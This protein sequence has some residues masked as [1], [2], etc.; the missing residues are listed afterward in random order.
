MALLTIGRV[1][2]DVTISD[3]NRT[4]GRSYPGGQQIQMRGWLS[5]TTLANVN[6]LRT[7]LLAQARLEGLPVS[8]TYNADATLDGFYTINTVDIPIAV[9]ERPFGNFRYP[10]TVDLT[11]LGTETQVEFQSMMTGTTITNHVGIIESE[12]TPFHAPPQGALSYAAGTTTVTAGSRTGSDGAIPVFFGLDFAADPTWSVTPA[13]YLTGACQI[14]VS[15]ALRAGKEAPND[16]TDSTGWELSNTLVKVTPGATIG[17]IDVSHHDGSQWETAKDYVLTWNDAAVIPSWHY[18]TIVEN[19]PERCTLL[20][21]RDAAENPPTAYRHLL[22]LTL[23]RGSR[24]VEAVYHWTGAAIV[25]RVGRGTSEAAEVAGT[26]AG[27]TGPLGIKADVDDGDGNRYV[28]GTN[29]AH[30][31]TLA[32]AASL[33]TDVASNVTRFFI[34]SEIGG[35]PGAAANDTD[36]TLQLQWLSQFNERTRAVLR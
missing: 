3:V 29:V 10:F 31:N 26:P 22:Y 20:L 19:R 36:E 23:R 14:N 25:L 9:D 6:L 8:L 16:I 28:I 34:G 27:A 32:G 4:R 33:V 13:N 2:T 21:V 12:G 15:G 1:G 35:D 5:S 7:E 24:L 11:Y 18:V 30:T 17:E